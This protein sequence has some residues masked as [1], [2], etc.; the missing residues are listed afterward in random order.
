MG[1]LCR[2]NKRESKSLYHLSCQQG[3]PAERYDEAESGSRFFDQK[4]TC[5]AQDMEPFHRIRRSRWVPSSKPEEQGIPLFLL[6]AFSPKHGTDLLNAQ[7]THQ[8]NHPSSLKNLLKSTFTFAFRQIPL[9]EVSK[10]ARL[11]WLLLRE[12]YAFDFVCKVDQL[13][14]LLQKKTSV[15]EKKRKSPGCSV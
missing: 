5:T 2:I 14:S 12:I 15:L 1:S 11:L 8:A 4:D 6:R 9:T 13:V 10:S 3:L 7:K